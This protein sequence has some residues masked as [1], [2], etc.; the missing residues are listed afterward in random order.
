[1]R[2]I[3]TLGRAFYRLSNILSRARF[4]STASIFATCP[5][6]NR[7]GPRARSSTALRPGTPQLGDTEGVLAFEYAKRTY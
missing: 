3:G 7:R 2:P 6:V 5:A 1:M 4:T